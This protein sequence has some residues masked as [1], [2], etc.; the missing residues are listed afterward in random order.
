MSDL[1]SMV[2]AVGAFVTVPPTLLIVSLF[3]VL[4]HWGRRHAVV[5]ASRNQAPPPVS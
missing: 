2:V 4:A 3:L 1:P 5:R